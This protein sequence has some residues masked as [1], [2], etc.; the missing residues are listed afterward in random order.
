MMTKKLFAVLVMILIPS[1]CAIAQK[2][3][4]PEGGKPKDFALPKK[5]TFILE[6]G[7]AA[8]MVH[9]GEV[10]K[11]SITAV[12]RTGGIDEA[13]NE[14]Q[15]A[16]LTGTML[17][18]GTL[19]LSAEDIR[20]DAAMMGGS[21]D[22]S[23]GDDRTSVGGDVL[24]EAGPTFI[25]LVADVL[26]NPKFPESELPRL[27]NDKI[28]ELS[29]AK[30]DP[31]SLT[32]ERF[33]KELYGDHPYGRGFPTD[34]M[35]MSYTIDRVRKFYHDTF[36]AQRTHL[37]IVGHFDQKEMESAVRNAFK[38][39]ERGAKQ[40]VNIPQSVT[41]RH[42]VIIDRPGA[43][44][45][46]VEIGLPVIDPTSKGYISLQVMNSL[47]GGSFASRITSNIREQ[48]GYTY[49]PYSMVAAR[50]RTAYWAEIA[51]VSTNVTGPSIKEILYEIN[52]LRS[53][54]P[55]QEELKGIQNYLAG[56]FVL[57]N[58]TRQGIIGQ[59][60][61]LDFH[62]LPESYLTGYVK[63]VHAVTPAQIKDMTV[64]YLRPDDMVIVI[65]GDKGKIEEQVADYGTVVK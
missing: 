54:S 49:S 19:T 4:P 53:E 51:S 30:A 8:T 26:R 7:L 58:S 44:Q 32:T 3:T 39:W 50:Y 20:R 33:N 59:L 64:K 42:V 55:T 40:V 5:I 46:T 15:L 34:T 65:A 38:S 24:S 35:I 11:V 62:G 23:V 9:Y 48:K 28:R 25:K 12:M 21:I 60:S 31:Q 27:K 1:L 14:I 29:L 47:L 17:K 2:Q 37:Y 18:E 63:A 43:S 41:K 57:Q 13:P 56:T 52:R 10:P 6:N 61:F 22:V 36:N 45:S 16:S